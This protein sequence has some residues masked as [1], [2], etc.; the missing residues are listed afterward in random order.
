M[1]HSKKSVLLILGHYIAAK[2]DLLAKKE[3]K[4]KKPPRL[5][6]WTEQLSVNSINGSMHC[7]NCC[8]PAIFSNVWIRDLYYGYKCRSG[9]LVDTTGG[10]QDWDPVGQEKFTGFFLPCRDE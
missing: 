3:T 4:T 1:Y 5:C 2:I 6:H 8:L 7:L 10:H 9:H